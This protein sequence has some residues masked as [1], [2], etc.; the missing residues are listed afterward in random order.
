MLLN[1]LKKNNIIIYSSILFFFLIFFNQYYGYI[2]IFPEDSF[3]IFNSGYDTMIGYFPFKDYWTT[4]GPLLDLIQAFFF[5]IFDINWFSYVLHASFFNFIITI[6]TFFVLLKFNLKANYCFFYSLLV[7]VLSYPNAGIPFM[8][9]HS[10]IL[11]TVSL[12]IF[13]LAIK[14]KSNYYWFFLPILLGLS[15]LSKQVPAAYVRLIIGFLSFFYFILN[16]DI[17]KIFLGI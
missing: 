12:L 17:K 15:F 13:I 2:G 9:H 1:T 4:T 10:N 16:F 7:A 6:T 3:L 14:N 11:S 8:D 5:R